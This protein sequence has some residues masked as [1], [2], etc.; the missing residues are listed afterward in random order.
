VPIS[1][2]SRTR[3]VSPYGISKRVLN[4]YADYFRAQHG[5]RTVLLALG[6][7]YG[8]RQNPHGEAGVVAIFL[9]RMLRGE[10]PVIFGN[11]SQVRDYVY[12]G[13][14]VDSFA[15]AMSSEHHGA[16][17]IGTG[18]GT[19]VL[20]LFKACARI[21]GYKGEPRFEAERPGELQASILDVALAG[22]VLGWKSKTS[23]S[24]GLKETFVSLQA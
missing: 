13:D 1:E 3:P 15:R 10:T 2:K 12:V 24:K 16:V 11:G 4:D 5:I 9:G 22:K 17:N 8:P 7:V 23:L 18:V 20:Q 19:S 21:A 6:N 14:V